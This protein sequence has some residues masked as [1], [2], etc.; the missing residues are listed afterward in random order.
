MTAQPRLQSRKIGSGT[1]LQISTLIGFVLLSLLPVVPMPIAGGTP[2]SAALVGLLILV[3]LTGSRE[4]WLDGTDVFLLMISA[5]LLASELITVLMTGA[6]D[7]FL[8]VMARLYYIALLVAVLFFTNHELRRGNSSFIFNVLVTGLAVLLIAM[9]VQAFF[10]P[11]YEAGR[12]FGYIKMPI[13]RATGVPNSD[14]KLGTF[15]ALCLAVGLFYGKRLPRWKSIFLRVGPFI[16][17]FFTQ[18]R[19]GLLAY[20]AVVGLHWAYLSIS[21]RNALV[22]ALRWIATFCAAAVLLY[23]LGVII[24][25]LT[26]HGTLER[27]VVSRGE[28]TQFAFDKIAAAPMLG[29]GGE[30]VSASITH[31]NIHNT[32]LAMSV[33]SGVF[34]GFLMALTILFPAIVFR[35]DWRF[36]FFKLALVAGFVVE[37]SLYPGF[38]NEFLIIGYVAVKWVWRLNLPQ[39]GWVP[40]EPRFSNGG[41]RTSESFQL[42]PRVS[43]RPG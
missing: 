36:T 22:L 17:L 25:N 4:S 19:S 14:G 35:G 34:A 38:I 12:D 18:S 31:L 8:F 23:Y 21:S 11:E 2:I 37:H 30:E 41:R 39:H 33:K 40:L 43:A 16:G 42:G 26:G 7:D 29:S 15:L 28:L 1:R 5:G 6:T 3:Q 32:V 20:A 27:N 10:Y 24:T 9:L 13:P